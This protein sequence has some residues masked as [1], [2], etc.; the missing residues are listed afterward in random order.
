MPGRLLKY[1]FVNTRLIH[2]WI[3]VTSSIF[4]YLVWNAMRSM[5]HK[6]EKVKIHTRAVICGHSDG[7]SISHKALA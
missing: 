3:C 5:S 2:C 1:V 7:G 4:F 6:V